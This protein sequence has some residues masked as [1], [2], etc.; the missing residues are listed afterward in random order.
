MANA[1]GRLAEAYT[2]SKTTDLGFSY[3]VRGEIANV[4]RS[5]PHSGGY[6]NVAATYWANG[7]LNTLNANLSGIP[8]WTYVPDG[9]GRV[10]T[11]TFPTNQYLASGTSYNGFSQP[12]S[13]SYGS[14]EMRHPVARK[15][16][17]FAH[18]GRQP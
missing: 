5:S 9:E 2:G 7:L 8:T 4:Y 18:A 3:S 1:K 16:R 11:V 12:T 13:V 15:N 14:Q 17:H 10:D 6:Y